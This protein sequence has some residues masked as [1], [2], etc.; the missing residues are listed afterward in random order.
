[1]IYFAKQTEVKKAFNE[2]IK[3]EGKDSSISYEELMTE[4]Q[5]GCDALLPYILFN[6]VEIYEI[7][8][9]ENIIEQLKGIKVSFKDFML[10]L[11]FYD[12]DYDVKPDY[13]LC[14]YI[15]QTLVKVQNNNLKVYGIN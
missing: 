11:A 5:C 1:M 2:Y 10:Y 15:A 14:Y 8:E 4:N 13:D 7:D 12:L 3:N 9:N 6:Y